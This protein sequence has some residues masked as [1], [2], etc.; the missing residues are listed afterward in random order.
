MSGEDPDV[1]DL[2]LRIQGLSIR[3]SGSNTRGTVLQPHLEATS[4]AVSPSASSSAFSLV[5]E[6]VIPKHP[7]V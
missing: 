3:L 1:W 5:P 7:R 6:P 4:G 2:T